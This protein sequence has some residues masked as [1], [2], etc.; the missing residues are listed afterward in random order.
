MQPT[1][2]LL[3]LVYLVS[4]SLHQ[5]HSGIKLQTGN[6]PALT[7][8]KK[9]KV[10]PGAELRQVGERCAEF[11]AREQMYVEVGNKAL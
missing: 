7:C 5:S 6:T 8:L 11:C 10:S 2:V 1:L 4:L 9:E 3:L